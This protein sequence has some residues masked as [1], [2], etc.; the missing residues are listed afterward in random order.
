MI[1]T[2][3]IKVFYENFTFIKDLILDIKGTPINQL[4]N[5]I[6]ATSLELEVLKDDFELKLNTVLNLESKLPSSELEND[7]NGTKRGET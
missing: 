2:D 3:V 1:K 5:K 6:D 7:S 4:L